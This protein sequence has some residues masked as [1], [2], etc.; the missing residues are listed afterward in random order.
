V[1]ALEAQPHGWR[2]VLEI[3]LPLAAGI[4]GF[5]V[6]A[7]AAAAAR[8]RVPEALF[9]VLLLVVIVVLAR[10]AGI[11]FALPVGVAAVLAFDWYF[12]P[13]LRAL[14]ANTVLVLGTFLI[15][16][17]IV[18]E[19]TTR[20]SRRAISSER[21]RGALAAEQKALRRVA[22]LVAQQARPEEVFAAVTAEVGRVLAADQTTMSRYDA[23]GTAIVVGTW[24]T[25][26][27]AVPI[28][29]GLRLERGGRNVH[30]L[31][32]QTGQP[33][34][35][36]DYAGPTADAGREHGIRST[37]G[38][39]ITVEGRLWGV[40][41]V[42]STRGGLLPP[43]IEGR[44]AGFT[45]LAGTAIANTEARQEVRVRGRTGVAAPGG[46]AGGPG[47]TAGGGVRRRHSGSRAGALRRLHE[48][49]PV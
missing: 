34:R 42:A 22:T 45:E 21:A 15:M 12:L 27:A 43:D 13:P 36:D 29:V 18:A 6:T 49:E 19:A 23:D 7:L 11:L 8:A 17:V 24:S 46:D 44:L 33:A 38:A 35:I 10:G 5:A 3:V 31:V 40:M 30:T 37:V 48:H 41:F 1:A 2:P 14:D 39:P 16:S 25:T 28:P 32:L 9:T 20:A 26:G 4:A 47:G